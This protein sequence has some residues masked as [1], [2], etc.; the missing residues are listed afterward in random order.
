LQLGDDVP[1]VA[2]RA[3]DRA[4][5]GSGNICRSDC[6]G[7]IVSD[8]GVRVEP[9]RIRSVDGGQRSR[10]ER[11]GVWIFHDETLDGPSVRFELV[12]ER[13]HRGRADLHRDE[14]LVAILEKALR[15][16]VARMPENRHHDREVLRLLAAGL[17]CL[18]SA[19]GAQVLK[20]ERDQEDRER[21]Q[22]I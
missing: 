17:D 5:I 2:D 20:V 22:E 1:P 21:E 14:N 4:E 15:L 6:S 11:C 7:G 9:E 13:R 8:V 10:D 18:P 3:L 16:E 19:P 12:G